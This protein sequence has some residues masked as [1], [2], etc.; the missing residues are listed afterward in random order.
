MCFNS[1]WESAHTGPTGRRNWKNR[2]VLLGTSISVIYSVL[3]LAIFGVI[4]GARGSSLEPRQPRSR[5]RD[6]VGDDGRPVRPRRLSAEGLWVRSCI[7]N[8]FVPCRMRNCIH[9]TSIANN[10]SVTLMH[11]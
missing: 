6:W 10:A 3:D 11:T 5:D 8:K 9:S 2:V 4:S 1:D 7:P